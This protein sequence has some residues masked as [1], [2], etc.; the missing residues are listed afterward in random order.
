MLETFEAYIFAKEFYQKCKYVKVPYF[1]RDQRSRASS[2]VVLNL[3]ENSGKRT[4]DDQKH[5]Y[6]IALGSLREYR[7]ILEIENIKDPL[8]KIPIDRL[9]AMLFKLSKIQPNK[10]RRGSAKR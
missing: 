4:A 3:A 9:G 10:K 8:L 2:S 7:A 6:S 1:L 5:F